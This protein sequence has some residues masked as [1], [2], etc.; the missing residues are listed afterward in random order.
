M[1]YVTLA[2]VLLVAG[3]LLSPSLSLAEKRG[4]RIDGKD[5]AQYMAEQ[6]GKAWAVVI[7]IDT[8]RSI[9]SLR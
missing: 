4:V 1:R 2:G 6:T 9:G 5:P 8:Y 3:T 7:G